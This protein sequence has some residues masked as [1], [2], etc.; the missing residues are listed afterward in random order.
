[1]GSR[2]LRVIIPPNAVSVENDYTYIPTQDLS[3]FMRTPDR[4]AIGTPLIPLANMQNVESNP[5]IQEIQQIQDISKHQDISKNKDIKEPES[6][7]YGK[8]FCFIGG[9]IVGSILDPITTI[10]VICA[11]ILIDNRNLPEPFGTFTP[12]ELIGIILKTLFRSFL[13]LIRMD[14]DRKDHKH[15]H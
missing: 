5:E 14:L 11:L 1:M 12:Q 15:I 8:A 10:I 2:V 3:Y 13:I 9:M 4:P 6:K 7:S